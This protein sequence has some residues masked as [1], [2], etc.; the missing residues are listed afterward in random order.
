M[1]ILVLGAS[2]AFTKKGFNQQ[3]LLE[4]NGRKMMIDCGRTTPEALANAKIKSSDVDDIFVSHGHNDHIGGLEHIAFERYD[5]QNRPQ[6][7]K[8]GTGWLAN[9]ERGRGKNHNYAPRLIA[10]HQFMQEL[11]EKSLRGGLESMEGFISSMETFFEPIP[12]K[13]NEVFIWEGWE[14][15]LVQQIHIMTGSM[16]SSTY[17]LLMSKPNHKTVYF[18]TDSQ[19]CSPRQME[20]FYKQ[21]DII[22]QDCELIG[23]DTANRLYKFGSGVHA[24]FG[25]LAGWESANSVK[26]SDDIKKKMILSHYQDFLLEGKDFFGNPCDWDSFV[27]EEGFN[28]IAKVGQVFEI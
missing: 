24:N 7:Y 4:E 23:V 27:L 8:D 10:N 20:T 16:V 28:G 26:L 2:H 19:H 18:T 1:K 9:Q 25:Q 14:I 6:H 5:W 15:R 11:W 17:G 22:F 13:G 3:F 12:I 21:A